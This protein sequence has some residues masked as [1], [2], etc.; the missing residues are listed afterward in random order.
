MSIIIQNL[1]QM[2]YIKKVR[3]VQNLNLAMINKWIRK[4]DKN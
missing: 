2:K 4:S 3:K 1:V